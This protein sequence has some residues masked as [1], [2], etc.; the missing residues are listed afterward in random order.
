MDRSP[1][2]IEFEMEDKLEALTGYPVDVIFQVIKD[3]ILIKDVEPDIRSDFE[4]I[5][6]KKTH[7]FI[8]FQNEYL[9]E[10]FNA[11]I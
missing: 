4:G 9:R 6:F 5:V 10:I 1:L 3:G 2:E 11:P 7:D 8:R